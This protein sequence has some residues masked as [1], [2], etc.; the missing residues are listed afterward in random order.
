MNKYKPDTII[1]LV[2]QIRQ[3]PG[4]YFGDTITLTGLQNLLFGFGLN[5]KTKDIPPFDYFN[6]WVCKKLKI[7]GASR[8]FNAIILDNCGK[9]ELIA[10]WKFYELLDEFL[11]IKPTEIQATNLAIDNFSFYYSTDKGR[12]HCFNGHFEKPII[13]PAPYHIKLIGFEHF[14]TD[15]F[16]DFNY[17]IGNTKTGTLYYKFFDEIEDCKNEFDEMYGQLSWKNIDNDK[18]REEFE[19]TVQNS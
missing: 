11:L 15:Y 1:E 10:F 8:S 13:N 6:Y 19:K 9:D 18:I 14:V 17:V 5:S 12:P 4:M 7:E 2:Q 3:R 16:Y